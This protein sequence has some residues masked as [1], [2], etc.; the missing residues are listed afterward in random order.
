MRIAE[1]FDVLSHEIMSL[2]SLNSRKNPKSFYL[3][4]YERIDLMADIVF[5][6]PPAPDGTTFGYHLGAGYVRSYLQRHHI[7]S[8]Q[9][10]THQERIFPDIVA[11]ILEYN[12]RIVG[13]TCYDLNYP[14]V[15]LLSIALKKKNPLINVILGGPTA[16]F[17]FREIMNHTP[18]IDICVRGEGEQT[19]LELLQKDFTDL[20]SIRGIAFRSG[21]EI[22]STP[23]RPLIS[24]EKKMAELDV[25]PSP[26]L[27][28]IIPP[29]GTTGILTSRAALF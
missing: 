29:D 28:G 23:E 13:F 10:V 14:Y 9:F 19:M 20:E 2:K 12:P 11:G 27:T 8:D 4:I 1:Y 25:I 15:R 3:S 5:V 21:N 7:D 22:V 6:F 24:G 16:T 18:E 26:Y 17:S